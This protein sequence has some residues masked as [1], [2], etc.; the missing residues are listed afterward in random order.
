MKTIFITK[1][2]G[3]VSDYQEY[4]DYILKM[5]PNGEHTIRVTKDK[6]RRTTSQNTQFWVWMEHIAQETGVTNEDM[7]DYF[8]KK[9]LQRQVKVNKRIETVVGG[10]RNLTKEAFAVFWDKVK[11]AAANEFGIV[12]PDPSDRQFPNFQEHYSHFMNV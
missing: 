11:E 1:R 6:A 5:L 3:E 12:L 8:C 9:F 7:H 2:N 10:T 4:L